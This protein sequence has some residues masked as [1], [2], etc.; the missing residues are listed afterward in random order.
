MTKVMKYKGYTGSICIDLDG[1]VLHG[2]IEC[3]NDLVTY[4]ADTPATLQQEFQLAVDD[5]L[6]TCSQ[7]GKDP[8]KEL[9]GTFNV[10]IGPDLHKDIYIYSIEKDISLNDAVRTLLKEG[11][12]AKS[13]HM[14][15]HMDA[16][17]KSADVAVRKNFSTR[18]PKAAG[19][20]ENI[21][22]H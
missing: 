16:D 9:S 12:Q 6:E 17:R 22:K 5:Y 4:E 21:M 19:T 3:I 1:G 20:Y 18:P 15:I 10:R 7:L 11:M 14:H 2:K 13:V 8:D